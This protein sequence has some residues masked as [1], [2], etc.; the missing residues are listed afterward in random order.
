MPFDL[1]RFN[2]EDLKPRTEEIKVPEMKAWFDEEDAPVFTSRALTGEEFYR[3][4]EAV[5]RRADFQAIAAGLLSG[6]GEA[7]AEAIE[8]FYGAVPD[9]FARRVEV[10]VFGCVK[11]ALD[12]QAAVKLLTHYPVSA[13]AVSEAILRA[14]GEG[15]IPGESN[16]SGGTPA[17]AT[18]STSATCGENASSSCGRTSSPSAP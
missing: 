7:I 13:H 1:R 17:S 8:A 4:R 3:V 9:E 16:G 2:R 6:G 14:T 11:P 18:T 12:R 15:S 5:Q 10:L